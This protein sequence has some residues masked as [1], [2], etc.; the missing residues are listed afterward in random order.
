VDLRLIMPADVGIR[1]RRKPQEQEDDCRSCENLRAAHRFCSFFSTDAQL[2]AGGTARHDPFALR[3]A[4][5]VRLAF[6]RAALYMRAHSTHG[7]RFPR[8]RNPQA[9]TGAT[10]EYTRSAFARGG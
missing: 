5:T 7:L 9:T 3:A 10:R 8:G 2:I 6:A 4:L 1:L